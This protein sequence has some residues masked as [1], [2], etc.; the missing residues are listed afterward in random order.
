ITGR[1]ACSTQRDLCAV[2][3]DDALKTMDF[4]MC[5]TNAWGDIT[6]SHHKI[7]RMW[8]CCALD[9]ARQASGRIR[10]RYTCCRCGFV[11]KKTL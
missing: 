10:L 7:R 6:C 5:V 3:R 11:R 8:S 2:P 9:V 4:R 1:G